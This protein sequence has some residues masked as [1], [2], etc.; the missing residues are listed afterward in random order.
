[1]QILTN[2]RRI[3]LLMLSM[4]FSLGFAFAQERTITGKVSAEGEGP[5]P[6]VNVLIQGTMIGVI[7]DQNGAYTIKV[8]S[9]ATVL[10]FSYVGYITEEVTVGT[11]SVIDITLEPDVVSL[12][13]VVVTGYSTQRKR[14]IT[15]AIGVVEPTKL[16]AVPTGNVSNQLQGRTSGVTVVGS[17]QPGETSRVRI[18]G[19]SSFQNNDPLYIVDGVPTQDISSLNPNDVESL[20]VLKDAGAASIYGSRASNGVIIVTTKKGSKGVKVTYDMYAGVQTPGEGPTKDLLS[21]QEYANLQW[22]V[23]DN[24]GTSEVHPIYGDS[25]NPTPTIPNWAANTDWYD[26][27]TDNAGI[28]NHDLTLSG[29]T[30]NARYFAGFGYFNQ[31]GI[32]IH[33][34]A[35]RYS[36]R[37]NSEW[38]FLDNRIKVGESITIAM[39][40]TQSV[41]NLGEGSPIQMGSYRSQPIVPV[42]WTGDPYQGLS[43][44]FVE[45]DYGGTGIAPRLGNNTNVVANLTRGKDNQSHNLRMLGSAFIDIM[46]IKGLNFRSTVGG[47]WSEGYYV[48]YTHATYENSE[49]TATPSLNEGADWYSDWVW[50]NALTYDKVFGQHKVVVVA[51]YEA[52]KYGIGRNVSA[53][54]AGYFSDAV[55]FRTLTNGANITAA[56][57][58]LYTPTTLVSMFGKLDYSFMDKYLVSATLRRDGSSRFGPDTRYGVFPSFSAAWRI[59]DEA[60]LDGLAWIS[61]LKIRGSYGTMGN[62]LALSPQN[63]YYLYGGSADQSFYDL[64]GTGTS[65]L[66]GFRPVRIGNPDAK[67]ETNITTNIG[68]EAALWNN[69]VGIVFD[70]YTK[71][72]EDL[73]YNPELPG[74]AGNAAAPYV[75]VASMSN[76]GV[77]LELTYKNNWG[78]FGFNGSLVFT[79]V[80]NE[81]TKIAEGVNFFDS[82]GSRIGSF[83]RNQV[84]HPMSSFYGYEVTG[85]FQSDTEVDAAPVQDGAEPGFFRYANTITGTPTDTLID[86]GDRRFIGNPNPKFTYGINLAFT[87]KNWDLSAFFLGSYGNDIFN[88]NKWWIDFWPSFQGQKSQDLLYNSW[89]PDRTGGSIPKASNKS[90]FS[91]NT[92][93]SS[94]YL[95]DGSYLR[96]KNLQLGYTIPESVLSKV[97]VK[98]LRLYVQGVNLLTFTKYSGLDPELGGADTDFGIDSGNYPTVRQFIFG[99]NLGL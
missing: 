67:W 11:Q 68:F 45:G 39:R 81:I 35:K 87:Y 93:A 30:E 8:P 13:E 66:Q 27:F 52:V 64:N 51:G 98:S 59:G 85:L 60:F 38:S 31:D 91:T 41:A 25:D 73:L 69:K 10:V 71:Q 19:F 7:T 53:S 86:P 17:G 82:G 54:R 89:T 90:N 72:T 15:G 47:T 62:Q 84:G 3:A 74:T 33:T 46:I 70:W 79:T 6:G 5:A 80:N 23:Y 55:D 18:R 32:V 76:K 22:L 34:G 12:Q 78:D 99:I 83:V 29:G 44:L 95:E 14:D 75:N 57:S 92:Q 4:V 40:Q 48:N 96:L 65:S 26:A 88:W 56:N 1:M 16:T 28:Q 50:T 42:Y 49:N 37:F 36:G 24:D 9:E 58:D 97:K 94:Y 43:H 77:D 2:G 21:T 63:Q 61:D 20:N